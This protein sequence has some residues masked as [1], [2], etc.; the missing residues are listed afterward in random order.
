M[1]WTRSAGAVLVAGGLVLSGCHHEDPGPP[2]VTDAQGDWEDTGRYALCGLLSTSS[3]IACGDPEFFE[4][5]ACNTASLANVPP[6][7]IYTL[8]YRSDASDPPYVSADAFRVS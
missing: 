3:D 1:R 5:S 2:P 4:L 8:V 6:D 7:A